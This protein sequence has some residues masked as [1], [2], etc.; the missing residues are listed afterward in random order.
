MAERIGKEQEGSANMLSQAQRAAILEVDARS[1]VSKRE[2][3]RVLRVSRPTVRKVLQ[4]NSVERAGDSAGGERRTLAPADPRSFGRRAR[5][6]SCES[7]RTRRPER[8]GDVLSGAD[9]HSA[10]GRAS[11]QTPVVPAGQYHFEPGVEMQHANHVR[12]MTWKW[13]AG[14]IESADRFGGS[15]HSRMLKSSRSRPPFSVSGLQGASH[16]CGAL[17]TNGAPERVLIEPT[18]ACCRSCAARGAR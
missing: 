3:A 7:A 5:G 9:R 11:G 10:A 2:I 16:R 6:I 4:S 15:L 12:R 1:G 13:A 18:C 14:S 17:H 8:S